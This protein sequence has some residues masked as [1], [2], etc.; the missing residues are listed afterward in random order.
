MKDV[1]RGRRILVTGGT[2]SIG[3]ELV[4]QC[5]AAEAKVVRVLIRNAV[6]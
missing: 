5:L 2:G 3:S 6:L 1:V 4:R